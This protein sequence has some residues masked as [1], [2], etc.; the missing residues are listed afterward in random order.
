MNEIQHQGGGIDDRKDG[1]VSPKEGASSQEQCSSRYVCK[2]TL[3]RKCLGKHFY[4]VS[5]FIVFLWMS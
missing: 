2:G 4:V 5:L 1:C 3:I